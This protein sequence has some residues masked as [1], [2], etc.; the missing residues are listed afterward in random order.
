VLDVCGLY[1]GTQR[2]LHAVLA[3]D[4]HRL[5]AQQLASVLGF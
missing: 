3:D 1:W 4:A 2:R 5:G